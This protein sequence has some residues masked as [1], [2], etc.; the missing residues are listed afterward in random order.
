MI[1][2]NTLLFSK[3]EQKII[4]LEDKSVDLILCDLPY[5]TTKNKWDTPINLEFFW[6]ECERVIKDKGVIVLTNRSAGK[7]TSLEVG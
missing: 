5:G 3:Y 6:K 1:P 4:Q 2:L 7:P